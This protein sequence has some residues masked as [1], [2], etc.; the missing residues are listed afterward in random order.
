MVGPGH[1]PDHSC[2]AVVLPVCDRWSGLVAARV[3]GVG[4]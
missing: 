4:E 2:Q 3:V 1:G